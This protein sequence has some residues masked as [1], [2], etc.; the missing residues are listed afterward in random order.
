MATASMR[1]LAQILPDGVALPA[2]Q[3]QALIAR[4][5]GRERPSRDVRQEPHSFAGHLRPGFGWWVLWI[6]RWR[7]RS[8]WMDSPDPSVVPLW[9]M[10]G[11]M[12]SLYFYLAME[13]V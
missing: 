3:V 7:I 8:S 12:S 9:G 5:G 6:Q 11:G 1:P 4:D 10:V 2:G 13:S